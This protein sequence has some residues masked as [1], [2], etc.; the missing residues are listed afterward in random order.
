M[1]E[2][3]RQHRENFFVVRG[4]RHQLISDDNGAVRQRHRIG[5]DVFAVTKVQGVAGLGIAGRRHPLK[6]IAQCLLFGFG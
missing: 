3:M 2:F 4:E 5:A 6:R 1:A